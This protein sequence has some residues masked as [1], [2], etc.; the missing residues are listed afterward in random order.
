MKR[1]FDWQSA[2]VLA[3]VAALGIT[4]CKK[5]ASVEDENETPNVDVVA[6]AHVTASETCFI[7]DASKR[8]SGRLWCAE[9]SR[10]EDRC[11]ICQPQLEDK[12]RIFCKEHSLF[13]DEC[14]LC[15]PELKEGREGEEAPEKESATGDSPTAL[16]D[17]L[18]CKEHNVPERE[19]GICQPQLATALGAGHELKVRFESEL[20]A[21]KAGVG[22]I[23]ARSIQSQASVHAICEVSYN[24][25]KLAKITPLAS[26]IVKRVLVDLGTVVISGDALVEIHSSEVAK[27]KAAYVSA[28]VDAELKDVA[29][30]REEAL[31]QKKISSQRDFQEA[32][33][34]CKTAKLA[35]STARQTLQNYGFTDAEIEDIRLVQE[36][37]ALFFVR[38]PYNG[39]L[40]ERAA[41]VG[42][43]TQPGDNLFTL[44]DLSKMWLSLSIP[45]DRTTLVEKG[46]KVKASFPRENEIETIGELTWVS[47]SI[48]E[49]SRML[50]GRAVVD[51]TDLRLRSGM[52]GEAKILLSS[53]HSALGIPKE[54]IQ[55]YEN[56]PFVFVKLEEDLYSLR[57]VV[58]EPSSDN[59]VAVVSGL[60]QHESVV[61]D[62]AFTVMSE[63]LKSRLGAGCVDD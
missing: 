20:S 1:F 37:S 46:L 53:E 18:F 11:W 32:E 57:R 36:T 44:A 45:A 52:F 43:A 28:V 17:G 55:R 8:D 4:G 35:E 15:H 60:K 12:T 2:S 23:T 51:N 27:A 41:V 56:N 58:V 22:T 31:A 7:C 16:H 33:A 13:E 29:C 21:E 30:K 39:T 42:E 9:H 59:L 25:N 47:A 48:D 61:V 5:Q 3:I 50:K 40:V 26:G 19:C 62:G 63:F 54:A 49:K 14:F 10:Y 34:A 6:H 38:A 24:E